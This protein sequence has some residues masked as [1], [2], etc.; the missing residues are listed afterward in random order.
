MGRKRRKRRKDS[1]PTQDTAPGWRKFLRSPPVWLFIAGLAFRLAHL[2]LYRGDFW[3]SMPLLDDNIFVSW[4]ATI[5]REGWTAKSLG[6][7]DFNPAYSY[8]LVI[9][10]KLAGRGFLTV[11]SFQHLA[12]ALV[13]VVLYLLCERLFCRKTALAAGVLGAF[14]GPSFF[15]ESRFLGEFWIYLFNLLTIF[16]VALARSGT[17]PS[18]ADRAGSPGRILALWGLAGLCLGFSNIFRPNV[19]AF[20]PAIALWAV[21][22]LR[23]RPRVLAG[24]SVLFLLGLWLPLLPFQL[25][26]R[27]VAPSHGWGL[28]TSS[29]GVNFYLGNNPEADGLNKAPSFIRYGPGHEYKDFKEEAERRSGR[30]MDQ[31]EVSG[32][33]SGE[34]VKWM[35]SRPGAAASLMVRKVGFF[36]NHREPPDNFFMEIFE[37]FTRVGRIPLFPWGLVA[38]LGLA[39]LLWSLR[40]DAGRSFWLL[41]AYV[42]A[43]FAV[44]VLFYILS[45]YR[46]PTAAGL[47]PFAAYALVRLRENWRPHPVRAVALGAI[48]LTC[49]GVSRLPLIGEEDKAISHYSMGVIYANQGWEDKAVL[50]YRASIRENPRFRASYLN[51][52]ILQARRGELKEAVWALE[53]AL[54]LEQDPG[55]VR[56]LRENIA[57]LKAKLGKGP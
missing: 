28:T 14:Y 1:P 26:N 57:M 35:R 21:W 16:C 17:A 27:I 5:E 33:W 22:D 56:V 50:E 39:G 32:F 52:G 7:F 18:D 42:A 13:A 38:P 37:R 8:F 11:F 9:L 19:L 25:R 29:G 10:G 31:R 47:I 41:H 24:C 20:V 43:Y 23:G 49:F 12:G 2:W 54:R 30:T 51:L 40:R 6:I 34:A 3:L 36:W 48:I 53:G 15:Y 46:F 55:K 44:N 45:R 4:A